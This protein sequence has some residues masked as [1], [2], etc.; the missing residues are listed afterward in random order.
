MLEVNVRFLVLKSKFIKL[1]LVISIVIVLLVISIDGISSAQVFFGYPLKKV[2][3][4]YVQTEEKKIAIT[5][6]AA[7]GGDKTEKIIAILNEYEVKATFFLVG[8]WV[9]AYGDLVSKIVEN[10]FEIGTHSNSHHDFTKLDKESMRTDLQTSIDLIKAKNGG[11]EVEFFRPPY[12]AYNNTLIELCEEMKIIPIQW[13]I[14]SLD[15]KGISAESIVNRITPNA[16]NGSIVLCHNNS[17]HILEALPMLLSQ[18]KQMNYQV[19]TVGDIVLRTDY[20]IDRTGK[21]IPKL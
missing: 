18:L 2:P 6:D 12:G 13:N 5:F 3:V 9:E 21:Q 16:K 8:F 1:F 11:K 15:W 17:D 10:G 19:T 7:W 20:T 4:Y 14:D